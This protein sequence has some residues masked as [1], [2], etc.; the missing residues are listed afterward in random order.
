MK[1][2]FDLIRTLLLRFDS[3]RPDA[4]WIGPMFSDPDS[5]RIWYHVRLMHEAGY[6]EPD[7]H[8]LTDAGLALLDKIRDPKVWNWMKAT[9]ESSEVPLFSGSIDALNESLRKAAKRIEEQAAEVSRLTACLKTANAN[10]EEFERRYYLEKQKVED[11]W[12][13]ADMSTLLPCPFCGG[14]ATIEREGTRRQSCV[15]TCD[16]CNT[17]HESSDEGPRSGESWNRRAGQAAAWIPCSERMPPDGCEVLVWEADCGLVVASKAPG[18]P[19]WYVWNWD[20]SVP[21]E[22]AHWMPLPTP[23]KG[24]A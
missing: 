14:A 10:H 12:A 4:I 15:V 23:P 7:C 9:C 1:R 16:S 3:L 8:V 5:E 20:A 13:A 17:T 21:P 24:E 18:L 6:L 11:Y 22:I 2:D 19:N